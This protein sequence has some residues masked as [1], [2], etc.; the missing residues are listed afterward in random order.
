[1]AT[2]VK[3]AEIRQWYRIRCEADAAVAEV[4]IYDAIG[5]DWY[6]EGVTAKSF[7]DELRALPDSAKTIR[8]H[9]NSPGGDVFDA[10]AIANLLRAQSQEKGRT[11]EM[12]IE[13]LAAS[14]ASIITSA[15]DSIKIASNAMMMVHNPA[16]I[17]MGE[18]KDMRSMADALD[19]IRDSIVA[20]YRW[21][22]HLSAEAIQ[23]LM[24]V[25]T[26]MSAEE[27]LANG[28]VTEIMAPVK[29]TAQF[30]PESLATL[31]EIPEPY[32]ERIA[33][34]TKEP[35]EAVIERTV[36]LGDRSVT[37]R[38]TAATARSIEEAFGKGLEPEPTSAPMPSPVEPLVPAPAA[39]V[40]AVLA[41]CKAGGCLDLAEEL[42]AAKLTLD[43]AKAR[44]AA[45]VAERQAEESRAKEIRGLCAA[46]KLPELA[47][48][49]IQ[50]KTPAAT[51]KA[52]LTV[53]TAKL[54]ATEITTTL[55]ADGN[56]PAR[57]ASRLNPS[58]IYA[59]RNARAG[60]RGA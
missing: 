38:V 12:L 26:W 4:Y 14:A 37:E 29:V 30:R 35:M 44:I 8:V 52:Q 7:L 54:G 24:D 17:V 1:M 18:A 41:E 11:V 23:G 9:V 22:S 31:G 6:G 57:P 32:R 10:V 45:H 40:Q 27:A 55:P 60:Q 34:L 28:F 49:Y 59:E 51:V 33:A 25:A 58:A 43:E 50:A 53:I 2:T 42:I 36:R 19:S 13:A 47:E 15:G 46:A 39:D 21:V 5:A 3:G 16:G 48:G 20:T 56:P